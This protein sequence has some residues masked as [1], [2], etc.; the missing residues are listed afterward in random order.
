MTGVQTCALPIFVG[1]GA[2][3]P[4]NFYWYNI[5]GWQNTQT[6]MQRSRTNV[7][8]GLIGNSF[9]HDFVPVKTNEEM[10]VT[11]NYGIGGKLEAGY[12]SETVDKSND[13]VGNLRPYQNDI[14]QVAS[15]DDKYIYLK[16]VNHD[17]YAKDITLNYEGESVSGEAEVICLSGNAGDVNAIGN[18]KVKPVTTKHKITDNQL[19]YMVPAMSFSVIKVAY[20]DKEEPPVELP[21]KDVSKDNWYYD[22]VSYV[23]QHELMTG[24][25]PD[26][27]AP[28][29][30]LSRAQFA[31]ILHRMEGKPEVTGGKN[32]H[33][34]EKDQFYTNAVL[35]AS[36]DDVGIISGY[37]DGNFG[38]A[39]EMT[40]EQMVVMMRRY[41]E[42]KNGYNKDKTADISGFEDVAKVSEFAVD[43]VKWAVANDIIK[44]EDGKNILNPQGDVSRAVCA[45]IIQRFMEMK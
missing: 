19:K 30:K 39:D 13:F 40:R 17:N 37:E 41:A 26:V 21:F 22:Y 7:G 10:N 43:A 33:D 18:E 8:R 5:G 15:K 11:F 38:P 28:N 12:K 2:K 6:A 27:F 44:G 4:D 16:L 14:Y 23:F 3:D 24:I 1:A 9:K 45:T 34:V 29:D 31:T 42:Y 35:W 36:Q 20:T 32:F 25:K